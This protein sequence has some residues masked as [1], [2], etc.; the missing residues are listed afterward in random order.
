[1]Q[2]RFDIAGLGHDAEVRLSIKQ[3]PQAAAHHRVLVGDQ[4]ADRLGRDV[5]R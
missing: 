5:A 4:D 2:R 1:L 3:H